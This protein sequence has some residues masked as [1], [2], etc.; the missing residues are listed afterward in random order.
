MVS[1]PSTT[2]WP[3]GGRMPLPPPVELPLLLLEPLSL[4]F[5]EWFLLPRDSLDSRRSREVLRRRVGG[6]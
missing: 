3:L 2:L 1:R 4:W 5:L 6:L